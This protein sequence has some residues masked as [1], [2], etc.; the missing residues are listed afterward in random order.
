LIIT[1]EAIHEGEDFAVDIVI[2]DLVDEWGGIVVL[3]TNFIYIPVIYAY[4][5]CSLF[6]CDW[7]DIGHPFNQRDMINE[8]CSQKFLH[9]NFNRCN[10]AL[11]DKAKFFLI[12]FA[13]G[14]VF[15]S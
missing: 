11:M 5:N 4:S 3:G 9:L 10:F 7:Y 1:R 15:I 14:Y 2:D 8:T 12:G 6:I 13:Y